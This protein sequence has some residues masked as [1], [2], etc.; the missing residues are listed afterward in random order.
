LIN[1]IYVYFNYVEYDILIISDIIL[2]DKCFL[3]QYRIKISS[4]VSEREKKKEKKREERRKEEKERRES[5][6][7][8]ERERE[9]ICGRLSHYCN[10]KSKETDG[11]KLF[12]L[13]CFYLIISIKICR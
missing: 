3:S 7:E 12:I 6:R 2:A 5:E 11:N 8:R 4:K 9:N 13:F 10:I 1:Y